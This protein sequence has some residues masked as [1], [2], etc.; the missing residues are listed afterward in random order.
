MCTLCVAASISSGNGVLV[1][2]RASPVNIKKQQKLNEEVRIHGQE[3]RTYVCSV[4]TVRPHH[5][6]TLSISNIP[7]LSNF[8]KSLHLL[9]MCLHV[10][11]VHTYTVSAVN[12]NL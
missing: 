6:T 3:L 12:M 7:F 9:L 4:D 8:I 11:Y 5:P 2:E 1:C 10:M